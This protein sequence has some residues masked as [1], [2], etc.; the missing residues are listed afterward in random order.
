MLLSTVLHHPSHVIPKITWLHPS[1]KTLESK[2]STLLLQNISKSDNG[3]FTCIAHDSDADETVT[4]RI[5]LNVTKRLKWMKIPYSQN[6]LIGKNFISEC[7]SFPNVH[8][9][10][11]KINDTRIEENDR[12]LSEDGKKLT[13]ANVQLNSSSTISCLIRNNGYPYNYL[14]K[15]IYLNVTKSKKNNNKTCIVCEKYCKYGFV[16]GENSCPTCQCAEDPCKNMICPQNYICQS[17]RVSYISKASCGFKIEGNHPPVINLN[18]LPNKTVYASIGNELVLNCS[19]LG[20]QQ[21]NYQFMKSNNPVVKNSDTDIDE[22]GL[23]FGV[24]YFFKISA[25][26]QGNYMCI[27]KNSL[28]TAIYDFSIKIAYVNNFRN[29]EETVYTEAFKGFEIKIPKT[30]GIP[31]SSLSYEW[32]KIINGKEEKIELG[33]RINQDEN[34]NLIFSYVLQN[35]EGDYIASVSN[36]LS[37]DFKKAAPVSLKITTGQDIIYEP[38]ISKI[39]TKYEVVAGDT[40]KLYCLVFAKPLPK[41]E[42][43]KIDGETSKKIAKS[44]VHTIE[45]VNKSIE[46]DYMVKIYSLEE[47]GAV[48]IEKTVTVNVHEPLNWYQGLNSK[49]V[50]IG[51]NVSFNCV[52]NINKSVISWFKDGKN[53]IPDSRWIVNKTMLTI[54]KVKP[55]DISSIQ[56]KAMIKRPIDNVYNYAFH[57]S[58]LYVTKNLTLTPTKKICNRTCRIQC[59]FGYILGEDGCRICEC[60]IDPCL[61]MLC[62]SEYLC[63]RIFPSNCSTKVCMDP[64]VA[65]CSPMIKRSGCLLKDCNKS[66]IY[67]YV[68]L[69]S[70][71]SIC[72]CYNPCKNK[73]CGQGKV[74]NL[75]PAGQCDNSNCKLLS[76]CEFPQ[77]G[78]PPIIE[79]KGPIQTVYYEIGGD[80]RLACPFIQPPDS[81]FDFN[82]LK[83]GKE[84]DIVGNF[85]R[86]KNLLTFLEEKAITLSPGYESDE[87]L[88]SCLVRN[89]YGTALSYNVS[90]EIS[91]LSDIETPEEENLIFDS[92]TR[93]YRIIHCSIESKP[94][95]IIYWR[96][97]NDKN[98]RQIID[99]HNIITT[100]NGS[101]IIIRP[102]TEQSGA[103]ICIGQNPFSKKEKIVRNIRITAKDI[104]PIDASHSIYVFPSNSTSFPIGGFT[105]IQ[106]ITSSLEPLKWFLNDQ[107]ITNETDYEIVISN[108]TIKDAGIWNVRSS[109]KLTSTFNI[110]YYHNITIGRTPKDTI[111]TV[112]SD[113]IFYCEIFGTK[114]RPQ[115]FVNGKKLQSPL[116]QSNIMLSQNGSSLT[117]KSVDYNASV[118]CNTENT[119]NGIYYFGAFLMTKSACPKLSL[120]HLNCSYGFFY[121]N[122]CPICKCHEPCKDYTC[123]D[124]AKVC[125][126]KPDLT[127]W[128]PPCYSKPSCIKPT[129]NTSQCKVLNCEPCRYGNKVDDRGCKVCECITDP[130]VA[131]RCSAGEKCVAV[132]MKYCQ[133]EICHEAKCYKTCSSCPNSCPFG[134]NITHE[135]C[136]NCTC[137][138]DPCLKT[139]VCQVGQKCTA[140]KLI[141]MPNDNLCDYRPYFASCGQS[142]GNCKICQNKCDYGYILGEDNC[143]KNCTCSPD[144]CL[145]LHCSANNINPTK[146][147]RSKPLC[148]GDDS[149]IEKCSKGPYKAE[150]VEACSLSSERCDLSRCPYNYPR[151][152]GCTVCICES[153][154]DSAPCQ[155]DEY[156]GIEEFEGLKLAVCKKEDRVCPPLDMCNLNETCKF[157]RST[158]EKGCELC[159]CKDPCKF[160]TC[161]NDSVC[162]PESRFCAS[163]PCRPTSVRCVSKC[164]AAKDYNL[165]SSIHNPI[166]PQ[167]DYNCT[168]ANINFERVQCYKGTNIC[169]CVDEKTGDYINNTATLGKPNCSKGEGSKQICPNGKKAKVCAV[170]ACNFQCCPGYPKA[171]CKTNPCNNCEPEFTYN[172]R[173][174]DCWNGIN[175]CWKDFQDKF[176]ALEIQTTMFSLEHSNWNIN[177][178]TRNTRDKMLKDSKQH[179]NGENE[180]FKEYNCG[181]MAIIFISSF[182]YTVYGSSE[183]SNRFMQEGVFFPQCLLP[184]ILSNNGYMPKQCFGDFCWCSDNMG[185]PINN[186]IFYKNNFTCAADGQVIPETVERLKC[187]DGKDPLFCK[188]QCLKS[189]HCLIQERGLPYLCRA[190][191]CSN[192]E[193]TM[194]FETIDSNGNVVDTEFLRNY[195][196]KADVY[197]D[198]CKLPKDTGN[199]CD[200]PSKD[201]WYYDAKNGGCLPFKYFGCGGNR[202]L[203]ISKEQCKIRCKGDICSKGTLKVCKDT[204][205]TAKCKGFPSA[206][207][208]VNKCTCKPEF[209]NPLT[210]NRIEKVDCFRDYGQCINYKAKIVLDGFDSSTFHSFLLVNTTLSSISCKENGGFT[211]KQCDEK[212]C[213]CVNEF[214]NIISNKLTPISLGNTLICEDKQANKCPPLS[215]SAN[216]KTCPQ[217][218]AKRF[219]LVNG[220]KIEC[221]FCS[222]SCIL[223]KGCVNDLQCVFKHDNSPKCSLERRICPKFD[224][225]KTF[226]PNG[227][228]VDNKGCRKCECHNPCDYIT[229]ERNYK[230][231]PYFLSCSSLPC[232]VKEAACIPKCQSEQQ[233]ALRTV[234]NNPT[235][236]FM[237]P[238]CNYEKHTYDTSTC[239]SNTGVCLCT[240]PNGLTPTSSLFRHGNVCSRESVD[241][242][243]DLC[244][245]NT[246]VHIC[247]VTL[248]TMK[249]CPAYPQAECRIN[250]CNGCKAEFYVGKDKVDCFEKSTLCHRQYAERVE[251]A[252]R[253]GEQQMFTDPY[254]Q[255][256]YYKLHVLPYHISTSIR[257]KKNSPSSDMGCSVQVE[258]NI[259]NYLKSTV[260]EKYIDELQTDKIVVG[261]YLPKCR[262]L[263]DNT[264]NGFLYKQCKTI[265]DKVLFCFCVDKSGNEIP[266]TLSKDPNMECNSDGIIKGK[267]EICPSGK[268]QQSCSERCLNTTCN[269][270]NFFTDCK[271]SQCDDCKVEVSNNLFSCSKKKCDKLEP[272]QDS[273]LICETFPEAVLVFDCLCKASFISPLSTLAVDCKGEPKGLCF[274]RNAQFS[275]L[276]VWKEIRFAVDM[277]SQSRYELF[278]AYYKYP[279]LSRYSCTADGNFESK[280]C[281]G[282]N[283]F[284]IDEWGMPLE[285]SSSGSNENIRCL[286]KK[287]ISL[288]FLA[289]VDST[290]PKKT[291]EEDIAK[292]L[293][294]PTENVNLFRDIKEKDSFLLQLTAN[295]K[296]LPAKVDVLYHLIKHKILKGVRSVSFMSEKTQIIPEETTIPPPTTI[297]PTTTR[298]QTTTEKTTTIPATTEEST[299]IQ[300]TTSIKETTTSK[301]I[302]NI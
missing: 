262:K 245:K 40:L 163:Y 78:I 110:S 28:G 9:I 100:I 285:I 279:E 213:W 130:C 155:P 105:R 19:A 202:N 241:S 66:C 120:C 137:S 83:N 32:L 177:L 267:V 219:T 34:G 288:G 68:K 168:K 138:R 161:H 287:T 71:C 274:R 284:C 143:P 276:D 73:T 117:L 254:W 1:S 107:E 175:K 121:D 133:N 193:T 49:I 69:E 119:V 196:C 98:E 166:I 47:N 232:I 94:K 63:K 134:F 240:S 16:M 239:M 229:C 141:C 113:A 74:C 127:C 189:H 249:C 302:G 5:T 106:F 146:C 211:P 38:I 235:E 290:I 153:P 61:N 76:V 275:S 281:I 88:Y 297:I 31:I 33:E 171:V 56:C 200:K 259:N 244:P 12:R 46:G 250:P 124:K 277:I 26:N 7:S 174:V 257:Y 109:N 142:S 156:C 139:S 301:Y 136:P 223:A 65:V 79:T 180:I 195:R 183:I 296:S 135:T 197:K 21:M 251:Q 291:I 162:V 67:G 152:S 184:K 42:W 101:L 48:A 248:C 158:D 280:Q 62:P 207:C 159:S 36:K 186:A 25:K 176:L 194:R 85:Q 255:I 4:T 3:I 247:P 18:H 57:N 132:R 282:N 300:I 37:K 263:G 293:H 122:G 225:C 164:E 82:V 172:G 14:Y 123:P 111:V 165:M 268:P 261:P 182:R 179:L 187:S 104:S 15:T 289:N 256:L 198:I 298:E 222:C 75:K 224:T 2:S 13:I 230:C 70:G 81:S 30:A 29:R 58:F 299:T 126:A 44:F 178:Q 214:G 273:N 145:A 170:N 157:G 272:C 89:K 191:P 190:D 20:Q 258:L 140:E 295:D 269:G 91:Y 220:L 144:P 252:V 169:F 129:S 118:W 238:N 97:L 151:T 150:C 92:T 154:C 203:F 23:K 253:I 22:N 237:I 35:D 147:K 199:S 264:H 24:L 50:Q 266:K 233:V 53:I 227:Y 43:Y 260:N 243:M 294:L 292:Y 8:P 236:L 216:E 90:L 103:Y 102:T 99:D 206:L 55:S 54:K 167:I 27:A 242:L 215:C 131:A 226:C 160:I 10:I 208:I 96:K 41:V 51:S 185:N 93:D 221:E 205:K 17:T 116:S 72:E 148:T 114:I 246:F 86:I 212:N 278:S 173:I 270:E 286:N 192:C 181:Y 11:W 188:E 283:C 87:G 39:K 201:M 210:Y 217:G 149:T 77:E 60:S 115:W 59:P 52:P 45:N 128:K 234:Y 64:M 265:G 271:A 218:L 209:F 95:A 84:F 108:F 204:C 80:I 6:L 231:E 112:G 125:A 228:K